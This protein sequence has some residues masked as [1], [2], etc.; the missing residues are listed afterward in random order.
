MKRGKSGIT[1]SE[2]Q[3]TSATQL[4]NLNP[5]FVKGDPVHYHSVIG[6]PHDDKIYVI[7]GIGCLPGNREVAWLEGKAGCVDLEALSHVEQ[8][9]GGTK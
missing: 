5:I 1:A 3:K 4:G 8:T 9:K 6:G 2:K 7:R